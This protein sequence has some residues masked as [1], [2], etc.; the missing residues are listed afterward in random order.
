MTQ[1]KATALLYE[2]YLDYFGT[3]NSEV[4]IAS[5]KSQGVVP[6]LFRK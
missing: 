1:S 4:L 6:M 5:Q 2:K 3:V